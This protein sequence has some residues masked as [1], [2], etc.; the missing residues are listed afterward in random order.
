MAL[1]PCSVCGRPR[2]TGRGTKPTVIC[3]DCRRQRREARQKEPCLWCGGP[4]ARQRSR[5]YCSSACFGKADSARRRAKREAVTAHARRVDREAN[6]AGL[7][8]T[9]RRRLLQLWKR[10]RRTCW[11]CPNQVESVDHLIPLVRGGTNQE[12]NLVPACR[13]C[14]SRKQDRLPIEFRLGRNASSTWQPFRER[15]RAPKIERI[16]RICSCYICGSAFIAAA[17]TRITCSTEC[18]I[19]HSKRLARERYRNRQ[20]LPPTWH[21]PTGKAWASKRAS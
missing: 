15:A 10:Q 11:Y 18:S 8:T 19:E 4:R 6:A 9:Q 12:G 16:S 7:T 21:V 1:T 2:H 3:H 20:G 13:S 14:N 5:G 17:R